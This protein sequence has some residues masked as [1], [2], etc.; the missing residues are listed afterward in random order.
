MPNVLARPGGGEAATRYRPTPGSRARY[1][2]RR[3][4]F[5]RA[6][7]GVSLA[8]T[9]HGP[10]ISGSPAVVFVHGLCLSQAVWAHQIRLLSNCYNGAVW[11]VAYDNRGHGW[12]GRAP[13]ASYRPDQLA[14]DLAQVLQALDLNGSLVLVGHSLGG[15][16]ILSY[17]GRPAWARPVEPDGLVLVATAAG[18]IAERGLGRLLAAPGIGSLCRIGEYLPERALRA[19]ASP[20]CA[21]VGRWAG[22]APYQQA[23]MAGVVASAIK[24]TPVATALGFLPSLRTFDAYRVLGQIRARTVIINGDGD[25][26]APAEHSRELAAGIPGAELVSLPGVGHMVPQQAPQVIH[27]AIR[28]TLDSAGASAPAACCADGDRDSDIAVAGRTYAGI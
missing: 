2:Q 19:A 26:L 17:M 1:T 11:P 5:V 12:S 23:T 7:D 22:C 13:G 27:R 8:V 4:R 10:A 20:V 15:M 6:S 14:D 24:T 3:R 21:A 28:S 16:A 25:L 9:G 18:R